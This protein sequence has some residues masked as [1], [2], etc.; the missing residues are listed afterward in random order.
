MRQPLLIAHRDEPVSREEIL[1]QI[2]GLEAYPTN[3]TV[4]NY[5]VR[6]RQKLE[7]DPKAPEHIVTVHRIGYKF[8]L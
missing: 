7:D 6:L 8:L 3:R 2:W 4:D 5:V 1:N